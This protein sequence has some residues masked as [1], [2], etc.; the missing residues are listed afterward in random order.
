MVLPSTGPCKLQGWPAGQEVLAV[1]IVTHDYGV[2]NH[3]LDWIWSLFHRRELI[4]GTA[5]ML[6]TPG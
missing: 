3:S 5:N 6:K 2:N 1:A 4:P